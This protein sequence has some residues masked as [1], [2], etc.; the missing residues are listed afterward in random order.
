LAA[1]ENVPKAVHENF[2]AVSA[3]GQRFCTRFGVQ[4]LIFV[5][6]LP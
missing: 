5:Q 4:A 2:I 6:P 1:A 3:I